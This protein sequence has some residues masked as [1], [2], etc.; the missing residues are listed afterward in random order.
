[1]GKL[2]CRICYTKFR[3]EIEQLMRDDTPMVH[4]ARKYSDSMGVDTHLLEQSIASHKK[5]IPNELTVEDKLLIDRFRKGE[6]SIDEVS[7]IVA[8][9]V[10]EKMLKNPE[11]FRFIDYFRTELL[12]L[13][14]E[15]SNIQNN[16]YKELIDRFFGGV[17]PSRYC[18]KCGYDFCPDSP[19]DNLS[20][21]IESSEEPDAVVGG[22]GG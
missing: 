20:I 6:V 2:E 7:R 19:S 22:Y 16:I 8:V 21:P 12:R 10:F 9:K 5:H 15:E 13:K 18:K 17:L 1:M 11:Q 4:I 14:E 3:D